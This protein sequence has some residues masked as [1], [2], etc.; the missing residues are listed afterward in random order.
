MTWKW[1]VDLTRYDRSPLLTTAEREALDTLMTNFARHRTN[2]PPHVRPQLA[3]LLQLV[4]DALDAMQA[5]RSVRGNTIN[6]LVH[7]MHRRH[8]AYW[9]WTPEEW[10]PILGTSFYAFQAFHGPTVNCRH[11]LIATSYLLCGFNRLDQLGHFEQYTLAQK[12]FGTQCVDAVIAD[13][14][15][16]LRRW[17]YGYERST[18]SMRQVL[19]ELM[20][21]VRSPLLEAM[22]LE[23][24]ETII[25]QDKAGNLYKGIV[26]LSY[27]L[28]KRGH[29]PAPVGMLSPAQ[30]QQRS[31]ARR[32]WEGV[33][34]AWAAWCQRWYE[35][36]TAQP[37]TRTGRLYRLLQIGRWLAVHHPE[38]MSPADWTHE[39][40]V[41]YVAAVDRFT[42]GQWSNP[43][44]MYRER[45]GQPFKPS[46]KASHL[47]ALRTFFR[48]CQE[49]QWIPR[50]FNPLR[51]FATP[52]SVRAL[53][54]SNPRVIADD[55][56]AK[57]LHAG[58]TLQATDVPNGIFQDG[59]Q[60]TTF[61][62]IELI[63]ALAIT[64]LFA[65]LRRSDLCAYAWAVCAGN[66]RRDSFQV[67]TR[68]SRKMRSAS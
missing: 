68:C 21:A 37:A 23:A 25:R 61:Y 11:H 22:T 65:G 13:V 8:M 34:E 47:G 3:R 17:G 46:A 53:L 4:Q 16:E 12:I 9:A 49:W 51:V 28:V 7:A 38:M 35:T 24:L 41:E 58:L 50:R 31:A 63:R 5:K 64:W 39:V 1:P 52:R 6:L 2:W 32:A 14:S 66:G 62:P 19:C 20:L 45:I 44:Q 30:L 10:L 42:I 43:G 48:D 36:S 55:V 54:G 27:L 33:P 56:W 15:A 18:G 59:A 60:R 57:L 29:I 40:A 26:T 67:L